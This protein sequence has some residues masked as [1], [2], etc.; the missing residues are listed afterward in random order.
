ME[1]VI[2][3][4]VVTLVDSFGSLCVLTAFGLRHLYR[5]LFAE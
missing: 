4:L 1:N 2:V 3:W 5:R